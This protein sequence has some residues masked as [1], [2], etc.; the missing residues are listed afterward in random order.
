MLPLIL[1]QYEG[2][3]LL[4]CMVKPCQIDFKIGYTSLHSHQPCKSFADSLQPRQDLSSL[5][6]YSHSSG[7]EMVCRCGF[8]LHFPAN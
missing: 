6:D 7:Y 5:F 4:E 2:A 3:E 8:H 1:S